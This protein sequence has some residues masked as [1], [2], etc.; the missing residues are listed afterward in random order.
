L[1]SAIEPDLLIAT[2]VEYADDASSDLSSSDR[3]IQVQAINV[4]R[5]Y[6]EVSFD[7]QLSGKIPIDNG[8]WS[9]YLKVRNG[10]MVLIMPRFI[11]LPS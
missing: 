1:P 5:S 2:S 8:G 6:P 3:T 4:N 9:D 7:Y 11:V 10:M